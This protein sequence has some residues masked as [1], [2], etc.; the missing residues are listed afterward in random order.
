[1]S[2]PRVFVARDY[3]V[4]AILDEIAAQLSS[5]GIHVIRGDVAAPPK[6]T[7]YAPSEWP[8]L[9]G[10]TEVIVISTRIR[11]PRALLAAAPRLRG[12]VFPTIGTE[13]VDLADAAAL[14]LIVAHAPTAENFTA[15]AESTVMLIA[16]LSLDLSGK[17]TMTRQ[18]AQRPQHHAMRAR[19]VGGQTIGLIGMGRIARA[20]VARLQGWNVQVIAYDPYVAQ[21]AAPDGVTMVDMATLLARSDLVSI[22]VT[23]TDETRHIIG[24]AELAQMKPQ[25]C[26]VNTARGRA[27]DEK[28]LVD[29]LRS[30]SISGAALDVFE[31]EP[32]PMDSPL[33][34][35]DNVIL[36]S[37]IVGHVKEM[38]GSFV[39]AGVENVMRILRGETPVF[40]RN[41][42]VLPEWHQRM[43]RL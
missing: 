29:A 20:V 33:R 37:H 41:P 14:S 27:V 26:L 7:E 15:M 11:A 1:M 12:V 10:D 22:H 38:H 13:S 9:F 39:N 32:L 24:R 28:A 23:L 17:Q 35:L 43:A 18:N 31:Q 40:V 34:T 25:A 8:R 16:A 5:R 21:S 6:I 4:G 2:Q 42:T 30:G 19:L 3:S 36:T